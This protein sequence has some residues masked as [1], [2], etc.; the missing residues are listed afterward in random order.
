MSGDGLDAALANI[1]LVDMRAV[2]PLEYGDQVRVEGTPY[3]G[4][5]TE[6]DPDGRLVQVN[7]I[8]GYKWFYVKD[9][10]KL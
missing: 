7:T 9:V 6:F 2:E 5:I 10:R 8:A 3:T 1:K 4:M